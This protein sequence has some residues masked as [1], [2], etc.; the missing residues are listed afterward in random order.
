MS[1]NVRKSFYLD[2]KPTFLEVLTPRHAS[3]PPCSTERPHRPLQ[4]EAWG[5]FT[6]ALAPPSLS[7]L[8]L[9][10][11]LALGLDFS[12]FFSFFFFLMHTHQRCSF[13]RQ[14]TF[15]GSLKEKAPWRRVGSLRVSFC[16]T[17]FILKV[18]T[19]NIKQHQ[20]IQNSLLLEM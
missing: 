16:D 18:L 2:S 6:K 9:P 8:C 5:R 20:L 19:R 17:D 12:L 10:P 13:L 1:Q 11:D 15:Q 7:A 4:L 3:D 14:I